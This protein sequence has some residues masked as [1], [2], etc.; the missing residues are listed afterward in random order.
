MTKY[1][2]HN[3]LLE[4]V[5]IYAI[6]M[7]KCKSGIHKMRGDACMR[8][9]L[10]K[11]DISLPPRPGKPAIRSSFNTI[12]SSGGIGFEKTAVCIGYGNGPEVRTTISFVGPF[13][14]VASLSSPT[15]ARW[16]FIRSATSCLPRS[17][18]QSRRGFGRDLRQRSCFIAAGSRR[19]R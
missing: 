14:V 8:S 15:K 9:P 19:M 16:R 18:L 1:D 2:N 3:I 11:G 17:P 6:L 13:G 5:K 4:K 10:P 12:M 7:V